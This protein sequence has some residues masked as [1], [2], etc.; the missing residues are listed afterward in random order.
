MDWSLT[1]S[2]FRVLLP[3]GNWRDRKRSWGR[4]YIKPPRPKLTSSKITGNK[5]ATPRLSYV[6]PQRFSSIL[7]SY[8]H[9]TRR[10]NA[11]LSVHRIIYSP[12][13]LQ[14]WVSQIYP[15]IPAAFSEMRFFD[16]R[17]GW[18]ITP[19]FCKMTTTLLSS[20][21]VCVL[22]RLLYRT[23]TLLLL[24]EARTLR[25]LTT[26]QTYSENKTK[27]PSASYEEIVPFQEPPFK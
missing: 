11:C 12:T 6:A 19:D 8:P 26:Q 17:L 2:I 23:R 15:Q 3:S 16:S 22:A 20:P 24:G 10:Q 18:H 7:P 9:H 5:G 25:T 13:T 4:P 27:P 21:L 14:Q 1:V